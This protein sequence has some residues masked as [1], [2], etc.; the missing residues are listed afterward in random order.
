MPGLYYYT[1]LSDKVHREAPYKSL[2]R[3]HSDTLSTLL[4]LCAASARC[5][6]CMATRLRQK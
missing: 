2:D 1:N 5:A 4:M 6:V 3:Y